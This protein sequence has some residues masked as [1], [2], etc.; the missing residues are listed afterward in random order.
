MAWGARQEEDGSWRLCERRGRTITHLSRQLSPEVEIRFPG[1][2]MAEQ[3]AHA[4][5]DH[6]AEYDRAK[7]RHPNA[8]AIVDII[9][10]HKGISPAD[11]QRIEEWKNGS[12]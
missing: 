8:W 5:N 9:V 10:A 11:L 7:R 4:M 6:W 2:A 12:N 3:C 1:R